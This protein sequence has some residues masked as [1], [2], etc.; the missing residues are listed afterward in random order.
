MEPIMK[1]NQNIVFSP[2]VLDAVATEIFKLFKISPLSLTQ[3]EVESIKTYAQYTNMQFRNLQKFTDNNLFSQF[4]KDNTNSLTYV[5]RIE[6][7]VMNYHGCN[8]DNVD[9]LLSIIDPIVSEMSEKILQCLDV[10]KLQKSVD[11]NKYHNL[12]I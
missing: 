9:Q 8:V 6:E 1:T 3:D 12:H 2:S 11:V 7:A 10:E 4:L 5:L